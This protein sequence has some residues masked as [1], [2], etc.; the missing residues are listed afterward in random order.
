VFLNGCATFGAGASD[1]ADAIRGT[2]S[3]VLGWSHPVMSDDA[4]A[5]SAALYANLV[6]AGQTVGHSL[7]DMG[8]VVT[9]NAQTSSGRPVQS[10]LSSTGRSGGGDLRIRDVVSIQ[11][12][13]TTELKERAEVAI[14][15]QADD[16][17]PDAVKW[18]VIVDGLDAS[19]G[20][21]LVAVTIDGH[22][23]PPAAVSSGTLVEKSWLLSGT[24]EMGVD[25]SVPHPAQFDVSLALPEGGVSL[26]SVAAVLVGESQAT[27]APPPTGTVWTGHVT[28]RTEVK[29]G[30]WFEAEADLI[31]TLDPST[32]QYRYLVYDVTGGTMT[33]SV[34]GTEPDGGCTSTLAP[35][36]I[37]VTPDNSSGGFRIDS[38]STPLLFD[39]SVSIDGPEVEVMQSDCSAEF[40]YLNGP[41]GTRASG[42]FIQVFSSEEPVIEVVDNRVTGASLYGDRT[43]DLSRSE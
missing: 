33:F 12:D 5:A 21:A 7:R 37:P 28:D 40:A 23:A 30:V 11:S 27:P 9:S 1:L 25:V 20:S 3:V 41:Y 43:F 34:S 4:Q 32:A 19:E 10:T 14:I 15:G 16:G 24:L 35:V 38:E 22:A 31:F 42:V 2:S 8:D 6:D 17:A 29:P 13:A 39:G 26:D 36:E 18:Q